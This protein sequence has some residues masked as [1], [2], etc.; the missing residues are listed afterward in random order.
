M[1]LSSERAISVLPGDRTMGRHLGAWFLKVALIAI[2]IVLG[3]AIESHR[4]GRDNLWIDIAA[5]SPEVL[6][7]IFALSALICFDVAHLL[8]L[9]SKDR[10]YSKGL[11]Y[12]TLVAA[13]GLIILSAVMYGALVQEAAGASHGRVVYSYS[14]YIPHLALATCI[15]GAMMQVWIAS[16]ESKPFWVHRI[17]PGLAVIVEADPMTMVRVHAALNISLADIHHGRN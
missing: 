5:N 4:L 8:T 16:V 15:V 2:P 7:G 11:A 10:P 12:A 14:G 13:I 17:G 9:L 1:A 3:A 6:A